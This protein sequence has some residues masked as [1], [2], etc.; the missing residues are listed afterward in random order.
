MKKQLD[1]HDLKTFISSLKDRTT[2]LLI[3]DMGTGMITR[4]QSTTAIG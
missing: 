3:V 1:A 2:A 4:G